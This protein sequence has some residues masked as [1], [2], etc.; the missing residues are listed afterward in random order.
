MFEFFEPRF[1]SRFQ[2]FEFRAVPQPDIEGLLTSRWELPVT[3][4][5]MIALGACGNVRA[6]LFDAQTWLTNNL[7]A[8]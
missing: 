3:E 6:A 5:R 1:Q 7:C 2:Y 8:A 4:A